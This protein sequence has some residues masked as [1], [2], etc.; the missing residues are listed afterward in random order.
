[1]ENLK[2]TG[3]EWSMI[4]SHTIKEPKE[5]VL[6]IHS[7]GKVIAKVYGDI[8]DPEAEANARVL[9]AA[10]EMLEVLYTIKRNF[11]VN[12]KYKTEC[13]PQELKSGLN[14]INAII[15]KAVE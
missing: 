6:S 11:E 4:Y 7:Q 1:M 5:A 12:L 8:E 2:I 10:R 9:T 15:K 13:T 14:I 3:G